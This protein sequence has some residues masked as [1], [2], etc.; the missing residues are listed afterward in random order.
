MTAPHSWNPLLRRLAAALVPA[1]LALACLAAP[2]AARRDTNLGTSG[3]GA[4][5]DSEVA[6]GPEAPPSEGGSAPRHAHLRGCTI[7]LEAPQALNAGEAPALSGQLSC[8]EA[9]AA[10]GVQVQ[11]FE[12]SAGTP[13]FQEVATA[14]TAAGGGFTA[15]A[16]PVEGNSFLYARAGRA[17]SSREAIRVSPLVTLAGPAHGAVLPAASHHRRAQATVVFSGT[18]SPSD[19]GAIV[20]LQRERPL[21]SGSWRR[22]AVTRVG[23]DGGFSFSHAFR[24]AGP[25][26]LRAFLH[27]H[28]HRLPAVSETL[29]YEVA[30][31]ENAA[32][33]IS[34]APQTVA[35]GESLE[36]T[37]RLAGP[38][39][40]PVTLLARTGTGGF[41]AV[42]STVT[43]EDGSYAFSESP[44]LDTQYRVRSGA[45]TSASARAAVTFALQAT[46]SATTLTEGEG[47]TISGTVAPASPGARVY[48]QR[49]SRAGIGWDTLGFA[50]VGEGGS[51]TIAVP[52]AAAGV[53]SYRVRIPR[54][55]GLQGTNAQP[56]PVTTGP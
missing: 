6:P 40:S 25:L 38:A 43:G 36:V 9:A 24:Q 51:Y 20:A 19:E 7:A 23:E 54:A 49:L 37:G 32:L 33:T 4:P 47:L 11:I 14:V 53:A 5:A 15:T 22:A 41:S 28:G 30:A 12:R 17:R 18:V 56:I 42:A 2:A 34:L 8:A 35:F 3:E 44:A 10:G 13:G 50:T 21:G 26:V 46:P 29:S 27:R 48:L 55:G 16:P 52:P 39:G 31:S 45:E 1:V